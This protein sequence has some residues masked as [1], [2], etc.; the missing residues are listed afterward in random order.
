MRPDPTKYSENTY[1]YTYFGQFNESNRLHGKGILIWNRGDILIGYWKNGDLSTGNYIRID[2]DGD[3]RV[4]EYY[5]K[6]GKRWNR[7]AWY[8]TNG[9]EEQYDRN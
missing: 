7:G 6:D 2:S 4:G 3:F 8:K 9:S 5:R 1:D